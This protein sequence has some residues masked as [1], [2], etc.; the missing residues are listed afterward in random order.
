MSQL[1]IALGGVL[2][3]L[4]VALGAFGAHGLEGRLSERMMDIYETAV[5][6]HMMHAL[7]LVLIGIIAQVWGSSAMLNGAGWALFAGVLIFSGSL[8]VLSVTGI[9][10]LGAITP[11]GGVAFLAGWIML[12]IA[13][14]RF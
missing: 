8:Y 14:V 6:Y 10:W 5:Q 9:S 3:F 1:F 4:A 12:V 2:A 11:I 7:G 13:A